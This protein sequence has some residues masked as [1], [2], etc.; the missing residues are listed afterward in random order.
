MCLD[1]V[2]VWIIFNVEVTGH[3]NEELFLEKFPETVLNYG[4]FARNNP[5]VKLSHLIDEGEKYVCDDMEFSI[6]FCPGH[7]PGSLCLVSEE[8]KVI[9][10]GDVLFRESIGRTDLPFSSPEDIIQSIKGKLFTLDDSYTVFSGHGPKTTLGHEKKTQPFCGRE[11]LIFAKFNKS[12]YNIVF[13][14]FRRIITICSIWAVYF[15][16]RTRSLAWH[17]EIHTLRFFTKTL[18]IIK[19]VAPP[20]RSSSKKRTRF[21]FL[22]DITIL[23]CLSKGRSIWTSII[24]T[25]ILSASN[26]FEARR[27]SSQH[28]TICNNSSVCPFFKN[29]RGSNRHVIFLY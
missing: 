27:A 13:I 11:S 19:A 29:L 5:P 17:Q 14:W 23:F 2:F 10:G 21:V 4:I 22:R 16:L 12:L 3:K 15:L 6:L 18:C 8:K 20:G 7:S 26:S 25:F 9:F 28:K 1:Y 24:S